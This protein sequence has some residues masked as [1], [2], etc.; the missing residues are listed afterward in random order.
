M[1]IKKHEENGGGFSL[2]NN[3][4]N[5]FITFNPEP[6]TMG[7]GRLWIED[8]EGYVYGGAAQA[9]GLTTAPAYLRR[10]ARLAAKIIDQGDQ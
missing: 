7:G 5:A 10:M 4:N 2:T 8:H 1:K 6:A 3:K 9:S